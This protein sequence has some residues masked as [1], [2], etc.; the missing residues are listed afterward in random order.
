MAPR[1]P[2]AGNE[3]S[4]RL[5]DLPAPPTLRFS[6]PPCGLLAHAVRP[7]PPSD[8]GTDPPAARTPAMPVPHWTEEAATPQTR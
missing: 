7:G 4:G 1:R 6:P 5:G 8:A 2:T 3:P